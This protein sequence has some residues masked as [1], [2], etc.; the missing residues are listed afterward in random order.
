MS[1][2]SPTRQIIGLA[3]WCLLLLIV[4][5]LG[6]V[7]SINAGA[8]YQSLEQPAWAPPAAWFGPVW[9]TLYALMALAAW[10]VWR[11]WRFGGAPL[12]LGLFIFQ[13]LPN[14]LWS[15]LFFVWHQGAW[16]FVNILLL[17]GLILATLIGFWRVHRGAAL[18]LLPYLLWVSLAVALNLSVWQLN[19]AALG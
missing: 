8:F 4:A 15:W 14:V 9:T 11:R 17:W 7:A 6:A 12:A 2:L 3:G 5:I 16:S 10:L 13:L 19:P 1:N 18:L